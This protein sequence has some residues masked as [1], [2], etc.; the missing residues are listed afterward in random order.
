MPSILNYLSNIIIERPR[1]RPPIIDPVKID[2]I[3]KPDIIDKSDE[4]KESWLLLTNY[5]IKECTW[6]VKLQVFS[7]HTEQKEP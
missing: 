6:K 3:D 4:S 1:I 7:H 5:E 2:K